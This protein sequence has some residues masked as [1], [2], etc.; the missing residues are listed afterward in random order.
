MS[1][2]TKMLIRAKLVNVHKEY[3][4]NYC[5][6][7]KEWRKFVEDLAWKSVHAIATVKNITIDEAIKEVL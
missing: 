5:A 7:S 2:G 6:Y 1:H 3:G 4:I